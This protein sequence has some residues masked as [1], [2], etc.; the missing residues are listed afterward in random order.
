MAGDC[1]FTVMTATWNRAHTLPRLYNSLC[2]Q[3]LRGFEWVVVDDGSTDLTADLM[4]QWRC[5]AFFRVQYHSQQHAGK[6]V[7]INRAVASARGEYFLIL[8]SDDWLFPDSLERYLAIWQSI[9]MSERCGFAGVAGRCM[10]ADGSLVGGP[11]DCDLIDATP[12]EI[13]ARYSVTGDLAEMVRTTV[14][15]EFPLP[16][17]PGET[18]LSEG[19]LWF[20]M[21]KR[22]RLRYVNEPLYCVE[23]QSDGLSAN[24]RNLILNNPRGAFVNSCE[25]LASGEPMSVGGAILSH[26]RLTRYGWLAGLSTVDVSRATPSRAWWVATLPLAAVSYLRDWLRLTRVKKSSK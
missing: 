16:V 6:H 21:A 19:A 25:W 3:T 14:M 11:W 20:P 23:Y 26:I 4:E 12:V 13:R 9:P 18:F 5:N 8:D 17:F 7:A 24:A 1:T 15:R 10:R 2:Q 22:Y